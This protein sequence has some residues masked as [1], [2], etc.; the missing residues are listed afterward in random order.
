MS[1]DAIEGEQS[2]LEDNLI[3]SPSMLRLDDLSEPIFK[4]ILHPNKSSYALSPKPH[5]DP[6]N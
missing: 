3:F 4:P 6:R 5:D 1:N 2:H